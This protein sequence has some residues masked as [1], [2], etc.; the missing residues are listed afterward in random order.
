MEY[1]EARLSEDITLNQVAKE[2]GLS[3]S[4]FARA[5]R[6]STGIPPYRWRTQAR[7]QKAKDLLLKED[8]RLRSIAILCG[9]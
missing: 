3:P 8:E 9:P 2:L 4:R 1:F 6:L 7:V 5:F